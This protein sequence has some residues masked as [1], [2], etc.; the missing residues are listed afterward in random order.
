MPRKPSSPRRSEIDRRN[1]ERLAE[2]RALAAIALQLRQLLWRDYGFG[3]L[4]HRY[5]H[6]NYQRGQMNGLDQLSQPAC[7]HI[8]TESPR[9]RAHVRDFNDRSLLFCGGRR[10]KTTKYSPERN[11]PM[12]TVTTKDGV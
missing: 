7:E 10:R 5:A 6:A 11:D 1:P 8:A 3:S 12:T 2:A 4:E 9:N